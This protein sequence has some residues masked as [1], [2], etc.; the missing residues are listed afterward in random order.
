MYQLSNP[1]QIKMNIL[2]LLLLLIS[3]ILTSSLISCG[4]NNGNAENEPVISF[5]SDVAPIL[6]QKC[7]GCHGEIQPLAGLDLSSY[8]G[9]MAGAKGEPVVIEGNSSKSLLVK[10]VRS[11]DM[12]KYGDKLPDV[13]VEIIS[14]WVAQG[15]ADN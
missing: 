12:P 15:A 2:K 5:T 14:N 11:G 13:Q 10:V 1:N 3:G 8:K 4:T 6:D 7:I 9:V